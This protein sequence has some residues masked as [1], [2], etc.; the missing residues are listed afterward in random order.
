MRLVASRTRDRRGP[1]PRGRHRGPRGLAVREPEKGL[2]GGAASLGQGELYRRGGAE[3][4][5]K[6]G[7]YKEIMT[8]I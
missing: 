6:P 8:R 1:L 4:L 2:A 3:S 5:E 7:Q